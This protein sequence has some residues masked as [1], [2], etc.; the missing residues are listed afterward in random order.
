MDAEY[1]AVKE[2]F[3]RGHAGCGVGE[4][5][6]VAAVVPLLSC[7]LCRALAR[8][9]LLRRPC[10]HPAA[11]LAL[12]HTAAVLPPLLALTLLSSRV[13]ELS[14]ALAL[15]L[16][17]ASAL[18]PR[19]PRHPRQPRPPAAAA[20]VRAMLGDVRGMLGL[21]T[22]LAILAVDFGVMPRRYAKTEAA[23]ASPMDAGVGAFALCSGASLGLGEA[24]AAGRPRGRARQ[25]WA[26]GVLLALGLGR[27]LAVRAA[28]YPEHLSEYG[29]HWNFFVTLAACTAAAALPLAGRWPGVCAAVLLALHEAA[30]GPGGLRERVLAG[31]P[32]GSS[33]LLRNREGLASLPGYVALVLGARHLARRAGRGQRAPVLLALCAG[34]AGVALLTPSRVVADAGYVAECAVV[35]GV[36]FVVSWAGWELDPASPQ[37][38]L[39]RGASDNSLLV[40]LAANLGTGA[41][42]LLVRSTEQGPVAAFA[43]LYCYSLAV[44]ALCFVLGSRQTRVRWH[45]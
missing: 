1:R 4:T 36:A 29:E 21:G 16:L 32:R 35:C 34:L 31:G 10:A 45:P 8:L 22:A 23:G 15:A 39:V 13:A 25:L 43:I 2:A 40:F 42:N 33:L 3:V 24:L 26:A 44:S 7:A 11:L 19:P 20:P 37:T 30:L 28:A 14:A 12:E 9:L 27:G 41:V 38:A 18:L 6:A 5:V 17:A